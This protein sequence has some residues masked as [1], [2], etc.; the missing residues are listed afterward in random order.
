ML[1]FNAQGYKIAPG[2][3][4]RHVGTLYDLHVSIDRVTR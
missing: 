3:P 4:G 1:V 2:L